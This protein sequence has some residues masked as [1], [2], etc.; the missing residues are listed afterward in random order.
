MRL[1]DA[2]RLRDEAGACIET[3]SAFQELVDQQP[4]VIGIDSHHEIRESVDVQTL[5]AAMAIRQ[6]SY[7]KDGKTR[8]AEGVRA[9]RLILECAWPVMTKYHATIVYSTFDKAQK[10]VEAWSIER[11]L[12]IADPTKQMLKLTEEV[13]E[14]AA[15]IARS[16]TEATVDAVG[17][18]MV[19]LTILCQQLGIDLAES[20]MSAYET[21]KN[22]KG[23]NVNG[24]FVKEEDL[25]TAKKEV[26]P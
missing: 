13:G 21:I 12:H 10:D 8:E 14:L 3:T 2:E 24:V 11:G 4:T 23:K 9:C 22:R 20:Y 26:T 18:T 1:I 16:N 5:D 19:V 15:A 6:G 17:D 25:N 7:I